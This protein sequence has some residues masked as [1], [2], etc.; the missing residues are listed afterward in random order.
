MSTSI[1]TSIVVLHN[2]KPGNNFNLATMIA[3]RFNCQTVAATDSPSLDGYDVIV[4]VVPNS[5]D[6]EMPPQM[7]N[8]LTS[9]TL[10]GKSY[11]VVEI[12]NYLG[13]YNNFGCRRVVIKLLDKLGWLM[14]GDEAI[15]STP[16]LD[17]EAVE[18]YLKEMQLKL[19]TRIVV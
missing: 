17:E 10:I 13:L 7:E 16:Y 11:F 9:L 14:I 5:G 3:N 18:V 2:H 8:F 19:F 12:G 4:I 15:D 6:D 1:K